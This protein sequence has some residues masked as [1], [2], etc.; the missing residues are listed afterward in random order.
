MGDHNEQTPLSRVTATLLSG[1]MDCQD[2]LRDGA[3]P[4]TYAVVGYM[5]R[6]EDMDVTDVPRSLNPVGI[7]A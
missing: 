4:F 3:T 2:T 7:F 6:K 5:K 1:P